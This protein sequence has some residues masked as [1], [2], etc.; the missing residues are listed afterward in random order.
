MVHV[1]QAGG[2]EPP[3]AD[4][5]AVQE[6][7]DRLIERLVPGGRPQAAEGQGETVV[8]RARKHH[9][10]HQR[11]DREQRPGPASAEILAADDLDGQWN[12][13]DVLVAFLG[14]DDHVG[15]RRGARGC[16]LLRRGGRDGAVMRR[17]CMHGC[18]RGER[19]DAHG[20]SADQPPPRTISDDHSNPLRQAWRTF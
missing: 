13:L 14:S 7:A 6:Q 2:V 9:S 11:R 10:G 12:A 1:E 16:G 15:Q 20:R 17:R 19:Q 8:R 3:L 18:R 5:G 4:E